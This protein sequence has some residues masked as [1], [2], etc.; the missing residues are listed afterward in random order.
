MWSDDVLLTALK[1]PFF[2]E[3]HVC[4]A[5]A[6]QITQALW[7]HSVATFCFI[8]QFQSFRYKNH[9]PSTAQITLPGLDHTHPKHITVNISESST[10]GD[11]AFSTTS[12]NHVGVLCFF[13]LRAIKLPDTT[14]QSYKGNQSLVSWS[15]K[16]QCSGQILTSQSLLGQRSSQA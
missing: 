8:L 9:I 15:S 16:L 4:L 2:V 11:R 1:T 13:F 12:S 10:E 14:E 6:M 5:L 3:A 7:P